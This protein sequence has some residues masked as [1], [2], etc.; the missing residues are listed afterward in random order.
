MNSG[1]RDNRRQSVAINSVFNVLN[2]FVKLLF[3]LLTSMYASRVLSVDGIGMFTTANNIVSYF[4]VF[5][6]LGIPI[7]GV[8]EIAKLKEKSEKK[9]RVFTELFII[10]T[11]ST[12]VCTLVYLLLVFGNEGYREDIWLYLSCGF[13]LFS[14]FLN[15]DWLYKGNEEYRYITLRSLLV[16]ILLLGAIVLFVRDK[17]DYVPYALI[18]SL[19]NGANYVF[20]VIRARKY[21]RL[22]FRNI[23]I[24]RHFSPIWYVFLG[25]L[26]S[27]LYRKID[28]TM[29]GIL[30]GERSTAY[31]AYAYRIVEMATMACASIT[32]VFLPRLSYCYKHDREQFHSVLASGVQVLIF[33]SIPMATG[34][35]LL[36]PQAI[37]LL[38]GDQFRP[39]VV[40]I[41][42]MAPLAVINSI[43]DLVS[44]QLAICTGNEKKRAPIYAVA[45]LANVILNMLLIPMLAEVGAVLASIVSELIAKIGVLMCIQKDISVPFNPGSI[46]Q[47][48]G[49]SAVMALAVSGVCLFPIPV[50][51]KTLMAVTAGLAVYFGVNLMLKNTVMNLLREKLRSKLRR[52]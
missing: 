12:A 11:L 23:N 38:Y 30:L 33:L 29:L 27:T 39:S 13:L 4:A 46:L 36:A 1:D 7:Y 6:A 15:I 21:V 19:G 52:A 2:T 42:C 17:G 32:E 37:E 20:N 41:Q 22:N 49:A 5:S 28:V 44:Y 34:L 51:W 9:D 26:F 45:A 50:F 10:N 25:S 47:A 14:N 3:P 48:I 40:L 24:F 18:T 35:A 43:G 8:R 16:R 31:Y